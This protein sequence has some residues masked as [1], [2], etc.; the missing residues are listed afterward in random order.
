[1]GIR[2]W[3]REPGCRTYTHTYTYWGGRVLVSRARAK[4]IN[5]TA[6]QL[7]VC[8]PGDVVKVADGDVPRLPNDC[9][10]A[11][12]D[13]LHLQ[14]TV[15]HDPHIASSCSAA[16]RCTCSGLGKRSARL[17]HTWCLI[18]KA[19]LARHSSAETLP[20]IRCR[21]EDQPQNILQVEG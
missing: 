19:L 2:W 18:G 3:P 15:W 11:F 8:A 6:P 14:H 21:C 9:R 5:N 20:S 16:D 1:M 17:R 12:R 10:S 4:R 7:C 13:Q